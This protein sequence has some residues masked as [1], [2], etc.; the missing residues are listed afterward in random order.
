MKDSDN[1]FYDEE[2][3]FKNNY[4]NSYGSAKEV[5]PI[6]T[7]ILNP[8]SVVDL[9][10]GSGTWIKAF[11]EEGVKKVLGID[12]HNVKTIIPKNKFLRHDLRTPLNIKGRFD[13]AMSLEVAEHIETRYSDIFVNNL[14][15][16]SDTILF[17]A[18]TP[19]QEGENHINEQW[20]NFWVDKFEKHGYVAIDLIRPKI[21]FND[22]ISYDYR[23]N[24]ILFVK[25]SLLKK[26]PLKFIPYYDKKRQLMFR[27]SYAKQFSPFIRLAYR[28]NAQIF[29]ELFNSII[30]K[31]FL[32]KFFG[33]MTSVD[34]QQIKNWK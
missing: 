30:D 31:I 18:A 5:V 20:H 13:L 6:V 26:N 10:C 4:S 19:K 27:K 8:K 14:V 1:S 21:I 9:G 28:I 24:Q 12:F 25:E 29:G 11:D 2:F 33:D 32:R 34:I 17:G 22:K 23:Q 16:L 3:Y 7:K 15:K